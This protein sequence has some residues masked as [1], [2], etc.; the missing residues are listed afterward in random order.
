MAISTIIKQHCKVCDKVAVE[1]NRIDFGDS[2]LISL[3]CGHFS[4]EEIIKQA[5]Y[6]AVISTDG[7]SLM[8]FQIDG[9]KFAEHAN[10]RCLIADEQG[11]G[12]TI[13]ALS[14][15][16]LH[17]ELLPAVLVTKSAIKVQHMFEA[18]R[19]LKTN[20]IQVVFSSGEIAVPGFDLYITS[21]DMLKSE[22]VWEHIEPKTLI[23]DECQKIKNHSSGRA[24]A[25]QKFSQRCEHIIGL[26]GT[27]IMNNAGEYFTILNILRP[28][29]FPEF[30]RFIR[31]YCDSYTNHYGTKV[32]GIKNKDRFKSITS[33]FIIRRTLADVMPDLFKFRQPRKFQHVELDRKVNQAYD[34]LI[35][36]L[37]EL[38][39]SDENEMA[40]QIAIMT[41]MRQITGISKTEECADFI[42][43]FIEGTDRKIA[44]FA[45]H[46]LAVN[47]LEDKVNKILREHDLQPCV[48]LRAGDDSREKLKLL[49]AIDRRVII[50]SGI[51]A[52][53]GMD[54]LQIIC[55]DMI[56]L[57]RQWNPAIEEQIE[58]RLIRYGQVKPVN[59]TYFIASETIDE[60]FTEIV[61]QKRS[62]LSST[63]DGKEMVWQT[64]SLMKELAEVLVRKGKKS[65]RL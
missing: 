24:K 22:S 13:Q 47:L 46:H 54:G 40:A 21:Y 56:M 4:A 17:P 39:Y 53:E 20:R 65:W 9:V 16:S 11:L 60:Y 58:S 41:K 7:K 49:E 10:A 2:I 29:L 63:L 30:N 28:T 51:A 55:N 48:I 38:I 6:S 62:I 42:E 25:A 61:E 31:E 43:E 8:P 18:K 3:E 1:S 26:S 64:E 57:E 19:W 5:D 36:E 15:L 50:C 27:P 45:H 52:G 33:D 14:L 34:K 23:L 12:K 32:G 59:I 37:E 44:I 35:K